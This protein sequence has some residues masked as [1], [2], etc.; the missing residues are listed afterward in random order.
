MAEA[1]LVIRPEWI[2]HIS[3]VN[4]S[5]AV[6]AAVQLLRMPNRPDAVFAVSDII[7]AARHQGCHKLRIAVS[8]GFGCR[9]LRQFGNFVMMEP[10]ITTI[11]S[12][13]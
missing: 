9:R 8:P 2:I 6:S 12:A 3:D 4:Y 7:A 11:T 1:G 13:L 5:L 10:S